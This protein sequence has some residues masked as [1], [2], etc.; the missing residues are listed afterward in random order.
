MSARLG[1]LARVLALGLFSLAGAQAQLRVEIAETDPPLPAVLARDEALR[2]RIEYSGAEGNQFWASP[3]FQGRRVGRVKTNPSRK[4]TGSGTALGWF[5]LDGA[6]SVDEIRIRTGGGKPYREWDVL[7]VRVDVRGTG[8][9]G[10]HRARAPWAE[11]LIQAD[12]EQH[13][14]ELRED[15]AR[16]PSLADNLIVAGFGL[17]VVGLF[18]G[19]IAGPAWALW[20][21]RG[22]WRIAGGLPLLA[23]A[24]VVLRIIVDT[25]RDPTS[26]NLWPFEILMWGTGCVAVVAVLAI[27]K[28]LVR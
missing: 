15:R 21:W 10:E 22:A 7:R 12:N 26:H 14:R 4:H 9:P 28:R 16:A 6:D 13:Q 23:M 24:F 20:K 27:V 2:L 19:S 8:V 25:V 11:R 5:S 3:C 17:A 18:A 1:F